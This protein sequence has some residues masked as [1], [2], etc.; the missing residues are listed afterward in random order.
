MPEGARDERGSSPSKTPE[1]L[2]SSALYRE[3]YRTGE[4]YRG[5]AIKAV[6]RSNTLGG[7]RLGFSVSRKT[8]IAVKR[9]LFKRR[10][11]ALTRENGIGLNADMI[12]SPVGRLEKA[13]W[14]SLRDDFLCL[15][16]LIGRR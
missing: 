16:K 12:L 6:Y 1:S 10:I 4:R 14:N 3:I 2:N 9:N 15:L 13:T 5:S 8:G 7:I 11:R